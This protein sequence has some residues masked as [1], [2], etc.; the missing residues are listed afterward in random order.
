MFFFFKKNTANKS[1]SKELL[2]IMNTYPNHWLEFSTLRVDAGPV[3]IYDSDSNPGNLHSN[4]ESAIA[5]LDHANTSWLTLKFMECQQQS[6]NIEC[7]LF[8]NCQL[9][10]MSHIW[11]SKGTHLL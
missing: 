3:N 8:G 6:N 9:Q 2:E 4:V 7:G 10:I 1:E 11:H 5:K